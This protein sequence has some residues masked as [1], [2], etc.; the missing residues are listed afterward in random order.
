MDVGAAGLLGGGP[1]VGLDSFRGLRDESFEI[2]DPQPLAGHE[3]FH[4][5]GPAEGQ[6]ALEEQPVETRQRAGDLGLMLFEKVLHGVLRR[7][8][9]LQPHDAG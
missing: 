4:G 5:V 7:M 8:C 2:L 3:S 1:G 9:A 6:V